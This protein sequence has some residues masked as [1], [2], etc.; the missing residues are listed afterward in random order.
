MAINTEYQKA[1]DES[2][3]HMSSNPMYLSD[4]AIQ[5][6]NDKE[7]SE[8]ELE[9]I[10][11]EISVVN[12]KLTSSISDGSGVYRPE[13]L[14]PSYNFLDDSENDLPC[15]LTAHNRDRYEHYSHWL[16]DEFLP[17]FHPLPR[18]DLQYPVIACT[19][20]LNSQAM[21]ITQKLMIMYIQG[22]SG[23]GK[24]AL[25]ESYGY[26]YPERLICRMSPSI[27]GAGLRDELDMRFSSGNPGVLLWDNFWVKECLEKLK[28][29]RDII[30]NNSKRYAKSNLSIRGD[31]NQREFKTHCL[32]V[33]SSIND[34]KEGNTSA[35]MD[36]ITRRLWIITC[37]DTGDKPKA[38]E[39]YSWQ[40]MINAYDAIW[41]H[42]NKEVVASTYAKYLN[43]AMT[44][45]RS[46]IPVDAKIWELLVV[47]LA[48]W[49][50][51]GLG[52]L[53]EGIEAF[54]KHREWTYTTDTAQTDILLQAMRDFMKKYQDEADRVGSNNPI[55]TT[56]KMMQY[57]DPQRIKEH[58]ELVLP[59]YQVTSR[60]MEEKIAPIM[61]TFGYLHKIIQ[62]KATFVKI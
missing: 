60:M 37:K 46:K 35:G 58:I 14:F 33:M 40:G 53:E 44:Y 52:T 30:L 36:E 13:T 24:S 62:G 25:L 18:G 32:K 34:G 21:S 23:C 48:V 1:I 2:I 8:E 45:P 11:V 6:K 27:T 50:F 42:K 9:A 49:Q 4:L 26:H 41:G 47:P 31:N 56:A 16:R 39:G 29:H 5:A 20:L 28:E 12:D 57:I 51:V 19:M 3:V 59:M 43:R 7:L 61:S 55:I 54:R 22:L 15:G 38:R 17:T 10:L